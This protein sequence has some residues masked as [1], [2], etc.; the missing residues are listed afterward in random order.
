MR[1]CPGVAAG[2]P[3]LRN[4]ISTPGRASNGTPRG[5]SWP[6]VRLTAAVGV[7][8]CAEVCAPPMT[9]R[10]SNRTAATETGAENRGTVNLPVFLTGVR[11]WAHVTTRQPR[12][13]AQAGD[14]GSVIAAR[15][16]EQHLR[17]GCLTV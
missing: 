2:W 7:A 4:S 12:G 3:S 1:L 11:R 10:P 16:T 5:A 14:A 13:R 6:A 15:A 9:L 17:A 8:S